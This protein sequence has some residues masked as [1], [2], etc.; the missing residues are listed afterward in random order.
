MIELARWATLALAAGL[1]GACVTLN[2]SVN[3]VDALR[4]LDQDYARYWQAGNADAVIG[5]FTDN[6]VLVPHHGDDPIVGRGNIRA[7]WFDPTY[8]PTT[9]LTW[10]RRITEVVVDGDIGYVRGRATLTWDYE[11]TRTTIPDSNYVLIAVR[12]DA[13]WRIRLLTWNDDPRL[14]QVAAA[15]GVSN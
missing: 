4:R 7:F 11:G 12:T 10:E 2:E 15:P 6:A 9:I 5:L 14:W 13:G 8:A 3:D 1:L